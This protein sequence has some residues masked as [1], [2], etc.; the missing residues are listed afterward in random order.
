[1]RGSAWE[2]VEDCWHDDYRG[3]PTDGS[4]WT[5]AGD[6][7]YRVLRGGSPTPTERRR[8]R[9]DG[10]EDNE[11]DLRPEDIGFRVARTP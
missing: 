6:C 8:D 9:E 5:R 3:A 4:A 11:S 10:E 1:M 2:W 7:T